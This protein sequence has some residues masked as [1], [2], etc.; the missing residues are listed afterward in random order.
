MISVLSEINEQFCMEKLFVSVSDFRISTFDDEFRFSILPTGPDPNT[1]NQQNVYIAWTQTILESS[2]RD[3]QIMISISTDHGTT[4]STP[5]VINDDSLNGRSRYSIFVD[6]AV[7]PNGEL[8]VSWEDNIYG[9]V[10][11]AS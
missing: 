3:Q 5:I 6:P 10:M 4:F 9:I 7:G 11:D 8:Y 1:P 2:Q